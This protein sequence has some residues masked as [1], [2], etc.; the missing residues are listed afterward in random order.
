MYT[1][2]YNMQ[3]EAHVVRNPFASRGI[4]RLAAIAIA[5]VAA[6]RAVA[7]VSPAV[8]APNQHR[9]ASPLSFTLKFRPG[10]YENQKRSI[11]KRAGEGV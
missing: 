1:T 2:V 4:H 11:T 7:Q 9:V 3:I 5:L 8:A 6:W 10:N